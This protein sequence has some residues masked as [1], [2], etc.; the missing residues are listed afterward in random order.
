MCLNV[1]RMYSKFW[2]NQPIEPPLPPLVRL[3]QRERALHR[4]ESR[5][6]VI[7]VPPPNSWIIERQIGVMKVAVRRNHGLDHTGT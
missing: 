7:A 4:R 1:L 6:Q 3:S 5:R 2:Q